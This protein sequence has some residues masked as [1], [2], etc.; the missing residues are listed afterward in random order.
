[1]KPESISAESANGPED[2]RVR[3]LL[4]QALPPDDVRSLT[5]EE[6]VRMLDA[7]PAAPIDAGDLMAGIG[8]G[9]SRTP[10]T[11]TLPSGRVV[12]V[13]HLAWTRWGKW[14]SASVLLIS[15]LF[16]LI[17]VSDTKAPS[18]TGDS[19]LEE[20]Q[21]NFPPPAYVGTPSQKV[22]TGTDRLSQQPQLSLLL[23]VDAR[24]NVAS[25]KPITC[26]APLVLEGDLSL[27]TDG[28]KSSDSYVSLGPGLQ[29][30]QVDL[31]EVHEIYGVVVWHDYST[32]S[33]YNDVIVAISDDPSFEVGVSV[34]F[35]NDADGSSGLDYELGG[36]PA[37]LETNYGRIIA[38]GRSAWTIRAP[39]LER[40][41]P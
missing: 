13:P 29:W 32:P 33:V 9:T 7:A 39:L 20:W 34:V 2:P 28:N 18:S 19:E 26:S 40:L 27:V 24:A 36:D 21:M 16:F 41:L 25:G 17:Q 6:L 22:S 4:Q 23:P 14:A 31:G 5:D 11:Q 10:P 8:R 15:C 38:T 30:I 3:G 35:N 37:Y 1:M 12:P